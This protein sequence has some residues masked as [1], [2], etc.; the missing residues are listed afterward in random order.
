VAALTLLALCALSPYVVESLTLPHSAVG[1]Y[2]VALF[3]LAAFAGYA[4]LGPA[5]TP[6]GLALRTLAAGVLFALCT[7][8]RS[9]TVLL[10]PGFA[11]AL[12]LAERRLFAARRVPATRARRLLTLGLLACLFLGPYLAL[13]PAEHHAAW[14]SV[15]EG[16]GDFATERGYSWHDRDAKRFL[17]R[18]GL[19]PFEHPNEVTQEQERF[20]RDQFLLDLRQDPLWYARVLG[21]RALAT[22]SLRKL[23]P[24]RATDG[25]SLDAPVF[26][27]KYTT[28]VD[29]IGFGDR[30]WELPILALVFP[31]ILIAL[32]CWRGAMA[33]RARGYGGVLLCVL[34][35]TLPLPVLVST[36]AGL[37]TEAVAIAYFLAAGFVV[38]ELVLR[39]RRKRV[40]ADD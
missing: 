24:R 27:Y 2:L 17:V 28:T 31:T 37:E 38:Q 29:W 4:V 30:R 25:R 18:H 34:A 6:A 7:V 13:R 21:R 22:L 15:W 35:G 16:L 5:T 20:F 14:V 23:W 3:G 8:C 36:A 12:V 39:L 19:P 32:A 11:L 9:G 40:R 26:H 33:Q 10:V 1:F